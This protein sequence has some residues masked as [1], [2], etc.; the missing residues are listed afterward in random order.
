M[1]LSAMALMALI[2][3]IDLLGFGLIIPLLPFYGQMFAPDHPFAVTMLGATYSGFQLFSAPLW[4]RVSDRVGRRPLI[5]LSLATSVVSY[6]WMS[7]AGALWMLF[8]ARALQG[9]S[10][11][12]IGIAQAYVADVTTP[13]N[14]AK[15]MGLL[16]AAIGLGFTLGPGIGGMLAGPD[17]AHVDVTL[18]AYSAAFM[19]FLALAL[20]ALRLQESLPAGERRPGGGRVALLRQAFANPRLR[21]LLSLYFTTTFAFAGM[22]MTF[23]LWALDRLDW[24]PRPV[25]WTFLAVGLLLSLPQGGLTGRLTKRFGEAPLLLAGTVLIGLGLAGLAVA[26]DA[27]FAIIAASLV[28]LGSGLTSP[29]TSSLVSREAGSLGKGAILGVNQSVGAL[30]R[31]L[32]P[33]AAGAVFER[34]G[35][36]APYALGAFIMVLSAVLAAGVIRQRRDAALVLARSS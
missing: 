35:A 31:F 26:A 8:A 7:H 30:A 6:L 13:E 14:R 12:T 20:A 1:Q 10:A 9:L 34:F 5:L 23:G 21:R 29:A 27:V 28:A 4:G 16:G 33:A 18:P 3:F 25:G 22:E 36:G 19:S 2:V 24:G 17:P 32:G 11:G 15:G